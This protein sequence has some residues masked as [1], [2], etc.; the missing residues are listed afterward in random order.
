MFLCKHT[1]QQPIGHFISAR[2]LLR[3]LGPEGLRPTQGGLRSSVMKYRVTKKNVEMLGPTV[4]GVA[5]EGNTWC[6]TLALA[7]NLTNPL[8][9]HTK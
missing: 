2:L 1:T 8:P 7:H 3:F 5:M 4:G 6:P 9:T